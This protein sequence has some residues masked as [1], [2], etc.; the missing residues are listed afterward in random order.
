MPSKHPRGV[1]RLTFRFGV[2]P[3]ACIKILTTVTLVIYE[4]AHAHLHTDTHVHVHVHSHNPTHTCMHLYAHMH[5]CT[6]THTHMSHS[7]GSKQSQCS[8]SLLAPRGKSQPQTPTDASLMTG[9]TRMGVTVALSLRKQ[10]D[11]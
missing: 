9:T 1:Y 10:K 2:V 11:N 8:N 5:T 7:L 3:H 4:H 6:H